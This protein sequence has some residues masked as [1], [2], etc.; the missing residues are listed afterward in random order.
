MV[1]GD[2]NSNRCCGWIKSVYH[3]IYEMKHIVVV[4]RYLELH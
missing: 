2:C 3:M 4:N 1:D